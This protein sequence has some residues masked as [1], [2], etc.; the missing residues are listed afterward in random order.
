M[1][2]PGAMAVHQAAAQQA[3]W[4]IVRAIEAAFAPVVTGDAA[5]E[6]AGPMVVMVTVMAAP[7]TVCMEEAAAALAADTLAAERWEAAVR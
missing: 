5:V 7:A 3:M 2:I 4:V 1:A 6:V